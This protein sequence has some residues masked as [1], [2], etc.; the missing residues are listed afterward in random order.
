MAKDGAKSFYHHYYLGICN[1]KDKAT[2]FF[3]LFFLF[4][5]IER[6]S[7]RTRIPLIEDN[8]ALLFFVYHLK[9]KKRN[10]YKKFESC[11]CSRTRS[12]VTQN[13]TSW[14]LFFQN[15]M[16]CIHLLGLIFFLWCLQKLPEA[17][18]QENLSQ[19]GKKREEIVELK[20]NLPFYSL[21][22]QMIFSRGTSSCSPIRPKEQSCMQLAHAD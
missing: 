8:Q 13:Y 21:F 18:L 22:A 6:I 9:N 12:H 17:E 19:G 20:P 5:F 7:F 4:S 14:A 1:R 2:S 11:D 15:P 3:F 10:K 16:P